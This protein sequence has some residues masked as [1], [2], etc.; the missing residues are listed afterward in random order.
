M[1]VLDNHVLMDQACQGPKG[2]GAL[3]RRRGVSL[4]HRGHLRCQSSWGEA[5]LE[6]GR[7]D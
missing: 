4:E 2:K 1:L 3:L 7:K 5:G 6:S